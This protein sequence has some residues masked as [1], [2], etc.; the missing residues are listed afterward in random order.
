MVVAKLEAK[1]YP[2]NIFASGGG[3]KKAILFTSD[4]TR[5][6]ELPGHTNAVHSFS[7]TS[8][9][10]ILTGSWDGKAREWPSTHGA[11][12]YVYPDHKNSAVVL[13]LSTGEVVTAGGEGD[14]RVYRNHVLVK[15]NKKAHGHV[16]RKVVEHPLGFATCANDGAV[17]VWSNEGDCL[18]SFVAYGLETKFVYGLCVIPSSNELVTCDDGSQVK[19]WTPDGKPVQT[20]PHPSVVRAVQ[21]LPNGDIVTCGSDGMARIFTR[22]SQRVAGIQEVQ[23]FQ[24]ASSQGMQEIDLKSLPG[25]AELMKPGAKDG[26]VRIFNV[27][28]KAMV[29]RWSQDDLKW[30]LV[31]QAMGSGRGKPKPKKTKLD[32]KEYDHVTKVFITESQS[33]M[34]GWNVDDDPR[35]VVDSFATLY[36]LP[37]D[38]KQQVYNFVAPKTNPQ[39]IA[40]RKERERKER[41]A[42]ATRHVPVHVKVGMKLF[43]DTKNISAMKSRLR[44]T[45]TKHSATKSQ[46]EAFSLLMSTIENTSKYHSSSFTKAEKEI[47]LTMIE[48]KGKEVLAVLD[49]LRLL[50]QHADAIKTLSKDPKLQIKLLSFIS[51]PNAPKFQLAL[52]FR[53]LAN[54]V[55]R[56]PRTEMERKKI[57]APLEIKN[58]FKDAVAATTTIL[59]TSNDK[60]VLSA[61]CVFL[62]NLICWMGTSSLDTP[63]LAIQIVDA[64]IPVLV[65]GKGPG[66]SLYYALVAV[67]SAAMAFEEIKKHASEKAKSVKSAVTGAQGKSQ[68]VIEALEDFVKVFGCD[69][70]NVTDIKIC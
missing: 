5:I 53:V 1:G 31:G 69:K 7:V 56:R 36:S 63:Q 18:V 66:N 29:Y 62:C 64:L 27:Q 17:K 54:Y 43:S 2:S 16:V 35:D 20:I 59:H 65:A 22:S 33:V 37:E 34:L 28:N 40:A 26:Q 45:L 39:A 14:V 61:G 4:G 55:G 19:I 21:A 15:A 41:V 6:A 38:L 47:V 44:Q 30:V 51:D 11:K 46:L 68:A 70:H 50:M 49:S 3:D 10:L 57:G 67:A 23:A 8:S 52:S 13:G 48:W 25:E 12:P 24:S 9:G 60:T 42:N 32:G 58:F